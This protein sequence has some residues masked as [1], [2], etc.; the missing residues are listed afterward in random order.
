MGGFC[1]YGQ[2]MEVARARAAK[3]I[4]TF[5]SEAKRPLTEVEWRERVD[6]EASGIFTRMKPVRVSPEF[7]APQ[8]AR[9]FIDLAARTAPPLT[10]SRTW[11]SCASTRSSTLKETRSRAKPAA[12]R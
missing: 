7:D 4:S 12:S 3:K 2:S 8:F 6:E 10:L 5:D 11:P 9:D 1:V